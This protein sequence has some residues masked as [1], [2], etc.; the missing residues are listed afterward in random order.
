MVQDADQHDAGVTQIIPALGIALELIHVL[1]VLASVEFDGDVPRPVEEV[2]ACDEAA[3]RIGHVDVQLGFGE[4]P[5]LQ[6]EAQLRLASRLCADAYV[7]EQHEV[8][9]ASLS[10]ELGGKAIDGG[11]RMAR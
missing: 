2:H 7:V 5:A 4:P 11:P 6:Q 9:A 8:S 1:S 10:D 3:A